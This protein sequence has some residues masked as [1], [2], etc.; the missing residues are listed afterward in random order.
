[1]S[2]PRPK[3]RVFE[4]D[5]K[6]ELKLRLAAKRAALSGKS[7]GETWVYDGPP[8]PEIVGRLIERVRSL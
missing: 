1:M 5:R 3:R 2:K 7:G 4:E 6:I 8:E